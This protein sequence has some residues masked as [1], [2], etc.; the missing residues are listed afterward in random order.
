[1]EDG[2][3]VVMIHAHHVAVLS[4]VPHLALQDVLQS[5]LHLAPHVL[6][7]VILSATTHLVAHR[8][9]NH[10]VSHAVLS[11]A[12]PAALLPD[13][14]LHAA[15]KVVGRE[16]GSCSLLQEPGMKAVMA[17]KKRCEKCMGE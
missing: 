6:Q 11:L 8:N 10:V 12:L 9:V 5:V 7:D 13:A 16:T 17:E 2:Q 14:L 3:I 4:L 15:H 1:V